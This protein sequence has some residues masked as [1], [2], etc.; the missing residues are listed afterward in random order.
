MILFPSRSMK[1]QIKK[2]WFAYFLLTVSLVSCLSIFLNLCTASLFA[3][4]SALKAKVDPNKGLP[5][6]G[7]LSSTYNA[8][9]QAK[10][11][12]V[13]SRKG[14]SIEAAAP[15]S[16]SVSKGSASQ[17]KMKIYNNSDDSFD[18]NVRVRQTNAKG[19]AIKTD[20]FSYRLKPKSSN[21][22]SISA[23]AGSVDAQLDLVSWKRIPSVD[24]SPDL[25]SASDKSNPENSILPTKNSVANKEHEE[26]QTIDPK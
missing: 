1:N 20:S 2:K 10:S 12:D 18:A 9:F 15:L 11:V 3:Q 19:L 23:V 16:G 13:W 4:D 21:E 14:E 22:R 6:S 24:L 5:K 8:G 25:E 26:N 7:T 17:W